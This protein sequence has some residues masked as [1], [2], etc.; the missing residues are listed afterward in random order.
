MRELRSLLSTI[1]AALCCGLL[2]AAAPLAAAQD[3]R[4]PRERILISQDWRFTKGDPEGLAADLRYDVRPAITEAADRPEEAL[5]VAREG[6]SVLR[7]WVLPSA[8]DFIADPA[9]RHVR[10]PGDPGSDARTCGTIS[11]TAP[12]RA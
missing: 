6:Q 7:D 12:G 10:P 8:N 5:R 9:S 3:A 1:W 4:P 2:L 11:T